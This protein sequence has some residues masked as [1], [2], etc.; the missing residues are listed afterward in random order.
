[1]TL[2]DSQIKVFYPFNLC[3][4]VLVADFFLDEELSY[5]SK[6]GT[7]SRAGQGNF[8]RFKAMVC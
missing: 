3:L 2:E 4:R 8:R 7:N 5:K 6:K 1:M